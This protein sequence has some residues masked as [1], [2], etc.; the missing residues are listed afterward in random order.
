MI[1]VEPKV[2]NL[3]HWHD[4]MNRLRHAQA[5]TENRH[6][7]DFLDNVLPGTL[8]QRRLDAERLNLQVLRR[9]V[10][11]KLRDLAYQKAER[12]RLGILVPQMRK[13]VQDKRVP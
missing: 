7:A 3:R 5:G 1:A 13:L 6:Q 8:T 2:P 4:V 12:F 11:K 9:L 10:E